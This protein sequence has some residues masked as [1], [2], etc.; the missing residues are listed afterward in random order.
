MVPA[1]DHAGVDPDE[2]DVAPENDAVVRRSRKKSCAEEK[3]K[4]KVKYPDHRR[5]PQVCCT[6]GG[7]LAFQRPLIYL[8]TLRDAMKKV[9]LL[10][11]LA[12]GLVVEGQVKKAAPAFNVV[13]AT[14]PE[15]RAAMEQGRIT[16]R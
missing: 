3:N 1:I 15:M 2:G 11:S 4:G 14:I 13:E 6:Y 7:Q 9:L 8:S 16:S 12:A 5:G 10:L